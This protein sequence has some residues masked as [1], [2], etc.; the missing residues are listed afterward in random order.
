ML[1]F[2][3]AIMSRGVFIVIFIIIII[4]TFLLAWWRSEECNEGGFLFFLGVGFII[5]LS[6]TTFYGSRQEAYADLI[7]GMDKSAVKAEGVTTHE[8]TVRLTFNGP[9]LKKVEILPK[10]IKR[11]PNIKEARKSK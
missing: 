7:S 9:V 4:A 11:I 3:D 10:T 8:G 6:V 5:L 1:I 2:D